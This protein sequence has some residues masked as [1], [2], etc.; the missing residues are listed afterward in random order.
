MLPALEKSKTHRKIDSSFKGGIW[1][2]VGGK[3]NTFYSGENVTTDHYPAIASRTPRRNWLLLSSEIHGMYCA[4]ALYLACDAELLRSI[5]ENQT[6]VLGDVSRTQKVFGKLGD[7]LLVLPDFKVYNTQNDTLRSE[8]VELVLGEVLVHGQQ[9]VDEEGTART[10]PLNTLHCVDFNFP[11]F[12]S[13]GDSVHLT[14]TDFNDGYYTVREVEEFDLRFDENTFVAEHIYSCKLSIHAPAL[15]GIC[16]CGDRLWG[17]EGNTIY[18]CAPGQ[19]TNWYRYDGDAQ[20]SYAVTVSDN[21]PI[22]GCVMHAGRPVF[23]KSNSMIEIYGDSSENYAYVQTCLSGVMQ[24]SAASL[25]SVGGD[26]LYLS[27]NGVVCCSGST[28]KVISEPLGKRLRDGVA[29]TD[30]RK[31]YLSAVDE[32][33]KRALYVYDTVIR[34]WYIEDGANIRHLGYLNGDVFAY[35][36]DDTVRILGHDH[37]GHGKA[38]QEVA[39]YTEFHPIMDDERGEIVPVRL[40]VRVACEPKCKLTLLVRYDDGVW[41]E[42]AMIESGGNRIWSIPLQPRVCHSMGIRMEGVGAYRILSLVKEYK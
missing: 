11:D 33:G 25:C 3:E 20:S 21:G 15:Q 37:T 23:F 4:D 24:G 30:G 41:E 42:R 29:T 18:A 34:A 39:S 28:A 32:T 26:M 16:T 1:Q 12:F 13:P 38:E 17:Y 5:A 14:G 2:R 8:T 9:Y 19:V 10:I 6:D 35:C 7:E 36:T 22:T 27:Q 31:Y 40:A